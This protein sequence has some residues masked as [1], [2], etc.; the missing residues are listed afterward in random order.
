M[1]LV[2]TN[3]MLIHIRAVQMSLIFS[4][5]DSG[6]RDSFDVLLAS[7]NVL[8]HVEHCKRKRTMIRSNSCGPC[9]P[10]E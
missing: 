7:T 1:L 10:V 2:N 4:G 5:K 3:M 8:R 6:N 9:E